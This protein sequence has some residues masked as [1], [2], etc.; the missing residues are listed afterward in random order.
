MKH[1]KWDK[2]ATYQETCIALNENKYDKRL[3]EELAREM[4]GSYMIY[5]GTPA[6]NGRVGCSIYSSE[7]FDNM[8]QNDKRV[9]HLNNLEIKTL[10][11]ATSKEF[12]DKWE[13]GYIH[14]PE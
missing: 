1:T 6:P 3:A 4:L 13:V 8:I 2:D 9:Q 11:L 5:L 7:W 14:H 12:F 10:F